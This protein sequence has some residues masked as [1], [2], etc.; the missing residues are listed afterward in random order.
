[1]PLL[2]HQ[3]HLALLAVVMVHRFSR[4]V[5]LLPAFLP[6]HLA[7]YLW[8]L[9]EAVLRGEASRSVQRDSSES[10]VQ[11]VWY[12]YNRILPLVSRRQPRQDAA[13]VVWGS[14]IGSTDQQLE[15]FPMSGMGF[16]LG[17]L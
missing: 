8:I 1:M 5:G 10:C 2:H 15:G 3:R 13:H 17:S 6:W 16:L 4:N 11:A 14:L 9:C 7:W 12:L